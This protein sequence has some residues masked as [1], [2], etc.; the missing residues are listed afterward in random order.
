MNLAIMYGLQENVAGKGSGYLIF[1]NTILR[2][3]YNCR[4]GT[5]MQYRSR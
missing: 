3:E 4:A 1:L 5:R 2:S